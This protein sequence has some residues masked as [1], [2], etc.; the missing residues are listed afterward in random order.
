MVKQ[1]AISVRLYKDLLEELDFEA[2]ISG[3]HRNTII[4]F[5][6]HFYLDF[7][8]RKRKEM[9]K[10]HTTIVELSND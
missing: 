6:V 5:A 3:L 7:L 1:K 8:D 10:E 4:N 9:K 2:S